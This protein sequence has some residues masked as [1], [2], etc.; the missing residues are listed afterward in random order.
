M[1][2]SLRLVGKVLERVVGFWDCS[3]LGITYSGSQQQLWFVTLG[4]SHPGSG[5]CRR[6]WSAASLRTPKLLVQQGVLCSCKLMAPH[7]GPV[8]CSW[9]DEHFFGEHC[10]N[11]R[12]GF[13]F[14]GEEWEGSGSLR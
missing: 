13:A 7:F 4:L 2:S 1:K 5:R 8:F 14:T 6:G 11:I 12:P 10:S 3:A 9:G